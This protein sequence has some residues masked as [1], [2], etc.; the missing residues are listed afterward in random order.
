MVVG[1]CHR[2]GE[3]RHQRLVFRFAGRQLR[4]EL[5]DLRSEPFEL[6]A[7]LV[8]LFLKRTGFLGQGSLAGEFRLEGRDE[9]V[10]D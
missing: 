1:S 5:S 8:K 6:G 4:R 10:G 9:F 2:R 3:L 7:L